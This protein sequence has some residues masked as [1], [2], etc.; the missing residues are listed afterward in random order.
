MFNFNISMHS[1]QL[2]PHP[3]RHDHGGRRQMTYN[4]HSSK[5]DLFFG[6]NVETAV[7]EAAE[8]IHQYAAQSTGGSRLDYD[9][10]E[11][12]EDLLFYRDETRN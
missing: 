8:G 4:H 6:E 5:T 9:G 2:R 11:N 10:H 12:C 1:R 3:D 7:F